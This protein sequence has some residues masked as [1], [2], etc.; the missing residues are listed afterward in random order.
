VKIKKTF[1][2]LILA[3]SLSFMG[4]LQGAY[5]VDYFNISV[6]D[7]F[8]PAGL[9]IIGAKDQDTGKAVATDD[10]LTTTTDLTAATGT[11]IMFG[12]SPDSTGSFVFLVTGEDENPIG[13]GWNM[14]ITKVNAS[15][16]IQ[17]GW[18]TVFDSA[19]GAGGSF[20]ANG[21]V[22]M[23]PDTIGGVFV[24]YY[25]G[26]NDPPG[27]PDS[28]RSIEI[29]HFNSG[30][31]ETVGF[32]LGG[33]GE[34]TAD[35]IS[36]GSGGAYIVYGM[37][38]NI[39]GASLSHG[40][41]RH[42]TTAGFDAAWAAGTG[43]LS[44]SSDAVTLKR[45]MTM[46]SDET[47]GA[48]ALWNEPTG[49]FGQRFTS[50]GLLSA[51][52][53][54]RGNLIYS[55]LGTSTL[56]PVRGASSAAGKHY[57]SFNEFGSLKVLSYSGTGSLQWSC[58]QNLG[59]DPNDGFDLIG[60]QDLTVP[61]VYV[62]FD[63]GELSTQLF[64]EPTGNSYWQIGGEDVSGGS[65]VNIYY[66]DAAFIENT[67]DGMTANSSN[68]GVEIVYGNAD[69]GDQEPVTVSLLRSSFAPG[70]GGDC[71]AAATPP[72]AP[73]INGI[74]G[75]T[76]ITVEFPEPAD[77]GSVITQYEVR[78]GEKVGFPGN[79][80]TNV[81]PFVAGP[82]SYTITGVVNNTEY[83][84][85]AFATNAG[86]LSSASNVVDVSPTSAGR[87]RSDTT[88]KSANLYL[89]TKVGAITEAKA[90]YF[91]LFQ[92]IL[93]GSRSLGDSFSVGSALGLSANELSN[94]VYQT[95]H[96]GEENRIFSDDEVLLELLP[97]EKHNILTLLDLLTKLRRLYGFMQETDYQLTKGYIYTA[98]SARKGFMKR[99]FLHLVGVRYFSYDTEFRDNLDKVLDLVVDWEKA[100]VIKF[101]QV[102]YDQSV[103]EY[104]SELDFSGSVNWYH[105]YKEMMREW[106]KAVLLEQAGID[107]EFVD[108][109]KVDE[110]IED[111]LKAYYQY[112]FGFCL[113]QALNLQ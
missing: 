42:V 53:V 75:N 92:D 52:W 27:P 77:N 109:F 80:V 99:N 14:K 108:W 47:G 64:R 96:G 3:F 89:G 4:L 97:V 33:L 38:P 72:D 39:L 93:H 65:D 55:S 84:V 10:G 103:I 69:S 35:M 70:P 51:G 45:G 31:T 8:S 17:A 90:L 85:R 54:A 49:I 9:D 61:G 28:T 111:P 101:G 1:L 82:V 105:R 23:I 95:V 44:L 88:N 26:T 50:A 2:S 87:R 91:D 56:T 36:D 57:A 102:C 76:D 41:A 68:T 107:Y 43:V 12:T 40:S 37:G 7:S 58:V 15:A 62:F 19:G 74:A 78:H 86:G 11:D 59:A 29:T 22:K 98:E 83:S 106:V 20:L 21:F 48:I 24:L 32:P 112:V 81:V 113:P 94:V 6:P 46:I 100:L 73:V 13:G 60:S 30:G 66:S 18:P 71:G 16:A 25:T 5:A 34:T 63:N 104:V 67:S 79:E 110:E